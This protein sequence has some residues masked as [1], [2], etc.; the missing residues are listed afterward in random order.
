MIDRGEHRLSVGVASE[1]VT[2]ICGLLKGSVRRSSLSCGGE[3]LVE[4]DLKCSQPTLLAMLLTADRKQPFIQWLL[5]GIDLPTFD[6]TQTT[7]ARDYVDCIMA[8]ELY[9]TLHKS[10]RFASQDTPPPKARKCT[11]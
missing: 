1:R 3:S 10:R 11:T 6:A 9:E 8:G 2:A 7:D 5:R 4:V